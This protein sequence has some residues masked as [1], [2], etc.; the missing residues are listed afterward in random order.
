MARTHDRLS[1][2]Q[3]VVLAEAKVPFPTAGTH[4]TGGAAWSDKRSRHRHDLVWH[5][6][7]DQHTSCSPAGRSPAVC[8]PKRIALGDAFAAAARF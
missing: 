5:R 8:Q 3:V 7:D 6:T 4:G 1:H 2:R